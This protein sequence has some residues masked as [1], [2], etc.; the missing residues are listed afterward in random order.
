MQ[1]CWNCSGLKKVA[2]PDLKYNLRYSKKLP[3]FNGLPKLAP[4]KQN[5]NRCKDAISIL[6]GAFRDVSED[7]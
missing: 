2:S 6:T 5:Y 7:D 4:A 1:H 3:Q